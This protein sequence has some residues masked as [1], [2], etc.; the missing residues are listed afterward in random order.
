M[1][2]SS[3]HLKRHWMLWEWTLARTTASLL[4]VTA[5]ASS[6]LTAKSARRGYTAFPTWGA[7]ACA[8]PSGISL[9][10]P[11][12]SP[13]QIQ[14]NF[15]PHFVGGQV[16]RL[17]YA[18]CIQLCASPLNG[19]SQNGHVKSHW[20]IACGMATTQTLLVLGHLRGLSP[21]ELAPSPGP[22]SQR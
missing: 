21:H 19:Q 2:N 14:S 6:S 7:I 17:L 22:A 4:N 3:L 20:C 15:D 16:A 13:G 11:T 10:T 18:H 12:A 9:S 8:T 1:V 5:A